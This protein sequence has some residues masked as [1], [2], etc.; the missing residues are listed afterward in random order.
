MILSN[1][2]VPIKG[3][4]FMMGSWDEDAF[5]MEKPLHRVTIKQDFYI[6]QYQVTMNEYMSF[7]NKTNSHYPQWCEEGSEYN[8]E[9]GNDNLYKGQ[10]FNDDAP[11]IG[12]SWE[13]AKAYC[14]WR[15]E[16]EEK[17][18][19][20]PTEAEWEYVCRAGT[21]TKYSFGDDETKLKEYGWYKNNAKV[22]KY[23][24]SLGIR[25]A[26]AVGNKKPNPWGLYD[27][28]GNVFE[29]CEDNWSD[30]YKTTPRDG[31]ANKKDNNLHHS[32]RGGSSF[33]MDWT[34]HSFYR[35]PAYRA[36][37]NIGFRVVFSI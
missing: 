10:N 33:G 12:V 5:S 15:S 14:I 35:A 13:D 26:Y 9:T 21:T 17:N 24:W 37:I 29:W 22:K 27:M 4:T 32:T 23:V 7:A 11:I 8:L 1:D 20:L 19:R 6:C 2:F 3:G 36:H 34:C 31:S 28:H 30:D 25:K 18:Y 16:K